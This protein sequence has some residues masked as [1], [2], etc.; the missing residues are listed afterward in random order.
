[1]VLND[2]YLVSLDCSLLQHFSLLWLNLFFDG[3]LL[4]KK[5]R[6]RAW[7]GGKGHRVLLFQVEAKNCIS[8][9]F[10]SLKTILFIVGAYT[11]VPWLLS[12][13]RGRA[14]EEKENKI[15]VKETGY[16]FIYGQVGLTLHPP[17]PSD[18][19]ISCWLLTEFFGLFPRFYTPITR[20]PWDT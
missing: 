8:Q 13:K 1:M 17:P 9:W 5:G 18:A 19:P 16:F 10:S 6:Q 14:L 15:L 2:C 11:F 3:S 4:Q 7:S 12:F 20:L